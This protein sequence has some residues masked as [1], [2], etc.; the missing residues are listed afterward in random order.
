MDQGQSKYGVSNL[1]YDLVTTVSN[2]LEG[3]E[4]LE[5]YAQDAEQAGDQDSATAFR[6]LRENNRSSAQQLRTALGRV[7]AS[8]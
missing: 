1:E 3:V 4:V 6:T 5:K 8:S 2:L 7:I